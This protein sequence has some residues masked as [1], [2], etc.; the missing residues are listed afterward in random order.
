MTNALRMLIISSSLSLIPLCAS[1]VGLLFDK[2]LGSRQTIGITYPLG[3]GNGPGLL[4]TQE[5]VKP[6]GIGIRGSYTLLN[7]W[8]TEMGITAT[9]HPKASGDFTQTNY[10]N[11]SEKFGEF[12]TEYLAVGAQLDWNLLVNLHAGLDLRR[13]KLSTEIGPSLG[14]GSTTYTRPWICVGL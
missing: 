1:E 10:S 3:P 14:T 7:L 12:S 13:E 5:A 8:A 6:S 4:N 11:M 9:Y 2:Q